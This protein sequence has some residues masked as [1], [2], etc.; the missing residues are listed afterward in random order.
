MA[1]IPN[2]REE[3][4]LREEKSLGYGSPGFPSRDV[5][6]AEFHHLERASVGW[7]VSI[8]WVLAAGIPARRRVAG[9]SCRGSDGGALWS[10]GEGE[11]LSGR[12]RA[13]EGSLVRHPR[14]PWCDHRG[15]HGD[16]A[17]RPDAA[18]SNVA[19]LRR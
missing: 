3:T 11:A 6:L 15:L 12:Q 16:E 9:L 1:E 17:T 7:Q 2:S 18:L 10:I 19:S 8:Q 4:E 13:G 5:A 14:V